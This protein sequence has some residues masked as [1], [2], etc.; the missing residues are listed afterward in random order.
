MESDI[1]TKSNQLSAIPKR[2]FPLFKKLKSSPISEEERLNQPVAQ[3][4]TT[5]SEKMSSLTVRI[6]SVNIIAIMILALGVLYLGEY[7]DSLVE[8]ELDSM[9]AEARFV[10][11]ALSEGTV[12]PVFQ[13]SPIPFNDPFESEAIK[14]SLARNMLSRLGKSSKSHIKL[15]G[16]D[17][18]CLLYTSP[19]PRDKRQS[20]MPSS[21]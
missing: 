3:R 14:P 5:S 15:F 16:T 4:W 21:A 1:D 10:S 9:R 8:G 20:R 11:D 6:I 7:T 17:N 12:R 18:S 19:S 2:L 13:V